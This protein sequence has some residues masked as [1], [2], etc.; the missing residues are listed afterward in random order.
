[1]MVNP[2]AV[3]NGSGSVKP[4]STPAGA[5]VANGAATSKPINAANVTVA[6][7]SASGNASGTSTNVPQAKSGNG[8]PTNATVEDSA[9]PLVHEGNTP[10]SGGG[11]ARQ[12]RALVLLLR[13]RLKPHLAAVVV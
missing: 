9:T 1:M 13:P 2:D 10:I 5:P 3:T 6:G 4:A 11:T 7:A 8:T 12:T